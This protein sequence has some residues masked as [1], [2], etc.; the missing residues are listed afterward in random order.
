MRRHRI[1]FNL[2]HD[3][4]PNLFLSNVKQFLQLIDD[5]DLI[6]LF[7][8]DLVEE[9]VTETIYHKFYSK[10]SERHRST[11]KTSKLDRITDIL[12]DE[13]EKHNPTKLIVPIITCYA[14]TVPP[15]YEAGLLRLKLLYGKPS[16]EL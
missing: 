7:I 8:S 3:Y 5:P 2:L 10:S 11:L 14:K 9:D 1:N 13:M 12:I 6:T 15:N 4:N 16:I